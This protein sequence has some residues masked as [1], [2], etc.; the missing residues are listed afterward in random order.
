MYERLMAV[1]PIVGKGTLDDPRRPMYAPAPSA[2]PATSR[3]GILGFSYVP[4]DDGK[5][6][7][8]EFVAQNR[9]AFNAILGDKSL[10][11]FLKGKDTK[12]DVIKEFKKYKKDFD[13]DK[14]GASLP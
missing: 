14:I 1:V 4:S 10:K 2:V 9:T 6:A 11:C 3:A 5:F 12:D 7:L 13:F 8:V